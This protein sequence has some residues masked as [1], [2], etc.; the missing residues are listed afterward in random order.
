MFMKGE[1][2]MELI[3]ENRRERNLAR[4]NPLQVMNY[5]LVWPCSEH[6]EIGMQCL[7]GG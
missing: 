5:R 7:T 4:A 2:R 6:K 1:T 3:L